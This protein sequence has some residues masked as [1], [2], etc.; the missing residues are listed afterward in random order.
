MASPPAASSFRRKEECGGP[1]VDDDGGRAQDC[2]EQ[3]TGMAV[4]FAALTG[5]EIVLEIGVARDGCGRGKRGA[6][7]IGVQDDAGGVDDMAQRDRLPSIERGLELRVRVAGRDAVAEVRP[8]RFEH[9]PGFGDKQGMGQGR[10]VC[11]EFVDG[12]KV[13]EGVG[14]EGHGGTYIVTCW[15]ACCVKRGGAIH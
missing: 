8:S 3:A 7:E 13:A 11:D 4:A 1:V 10:I 2:L 5:R 14:I 9:A 12:G 6:S 15:T